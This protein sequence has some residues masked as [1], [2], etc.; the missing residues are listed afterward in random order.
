MNPTQWH[1]YIFKRRRKKNQWMAYPFLLV[2]DERN[3]QNRDINLELFSIHWFQQ[4]KWIHCRSSPKIHMKATD[5][6][7]HPYYYHSLL[8]IQIKLLFMSTIQV[9]IRHHLWRLIEIYCGHCFVYCGNCFV[10]ISDK[11]IFD[12]SLYHLYLYEV[13]VTD[14][15][16]GCHWSWVDI[17]RKP[18]T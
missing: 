7:D 11:N 8:T 16:N 9:Y 14:L 4:R 13:W 12:L 17:T 6:N 5:L 15:A 2:F 3:R 18:H 10:Y 1:N